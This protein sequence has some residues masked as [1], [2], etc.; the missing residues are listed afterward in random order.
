VIS[1]KHDPARR[2]ERL[3]KHR[4]VNQRLKPCPECTRYVQAGNLA[5][6]LKRGCP[7]PKG[8]RPA[9]YWWAA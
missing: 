1:M 7:P 2:E 5:R 4:A 3:A 8:P 6:H 9:S